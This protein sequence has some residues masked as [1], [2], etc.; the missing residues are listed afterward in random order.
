MRVW[1]VV[2]VVLVCVFVCL[3][4]CLCVGDGRWLIA[5]TLILISQ[6]GDGREGSEVSS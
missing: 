4:V 1:V 3:F 5:I 6:W 2:V